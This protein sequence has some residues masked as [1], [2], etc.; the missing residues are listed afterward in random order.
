MGWLAAQQVVNPGSFFSFFSPRENSSFF[1][2]PYHRIPFGSFHSNPF[3]TFSNHVVFPEAMGGVNPIVFRTVCWA[4]LTESG[5]L[6]L[7][8]A[9]F[10]GNVR[11]AFVGVGGAGSYAGRQIKGVRVK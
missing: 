7:Y 2:L 4:G 9:T 8:R 6:N 3:G 5:S 10:L 1:L 11:V